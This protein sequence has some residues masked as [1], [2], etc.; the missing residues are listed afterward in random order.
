M[1][2]PVALLMLAL[3]LGGCAAAPVLPTT[4]APAATAVLAFTLAGRIAVKHGD[5]GFSGGVRWA[6][7]DAGDEISLTSPLGQTVARITGTREGYQLITSEGKL[8][9]AP[10]AEALTRGTL[11]W[12]LP[13]RGLVHWLRARNDP[14][15]NA[16]IDIDGEGRVERVRQDGGDIAYARYRSF[17]GRRHPGLITLRRGEVEI[18]LVIDDWQAAE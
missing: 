16:V 4:E 14:E 2:R 8:F 17:D 13:V 10:D 12:A 7:G 18:K 6:H 11:G 5:Q 15:R 3:A 9:T 1:R